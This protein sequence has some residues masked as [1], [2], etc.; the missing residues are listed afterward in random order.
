[1]L[2]YD[3]AL[4]RVLDAIP[5]PL[6]P[7]SVPL[8]DA[9]GR[10]LSEDMFAD[11]D[12]PPF[13]NS[14]VDGYALRYPDTGAPPT[15]SIFTVVQTVAAGSAPGRPLRPREAAR[16]FTGAPVP[17]GT[18]V[19]VMQE[20][21]TASDDGQ[22]VTI[23]ADGSSGFLRRAGS[24]IRRGT[25]ALAAGMALDPGAIGILASLNRASVQCPRLPR[26]ALLTTG[27]EVIPVGDRPLQIGQIRDSNGP[28]LAAAIRKAGGIVAHRQHV[29]DTP[30]AV[31][32]A[33]DA[34]AGCDVVVT[35]GGVSVGAFDY[36]KAALEERGGLD[37][38]RIAIKPG[39]PLAFGRLGD[40]LLFGLPGNPVSSLV[41]FE[42]FVRPALR[43]LAGCEDVTRPL[44]SAVLA[45]SLS[46]ERGRREFVRA[47]LT[48]REDRYV[49]TPTGTQGSHRLSSLAGAD[50]YLIAHE[51]RGD[52]AIGESL[53]AM[54]LS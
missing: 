21:T 9:A 6:S 35:S 20:D 36:V 13:D 2:S 12:L 18:A 24:D 51:E 19:I 40:A 52:Y 7:E 41:T 16:L 49:A 14:A 46:H 5:G 8:E 15:G 10:V 44:V 53:P 28:A 3:E 48:W 54:L 23:H 45:T 42:L 37:F 43:K 50:A 34:C 27:D 30:T 4:A 11:S 1:M 25:L 26:V 47:R 39:K 38:W 29:R 33:L 32:Q 17:E 31:H 22:T